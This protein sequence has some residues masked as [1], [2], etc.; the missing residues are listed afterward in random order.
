[1]EIPKAGV[2]IETRFMS[3]VRLTRAFFDSNVLIYADDKG[4]PEKQRIARELIERYF[5]L[6]YGVVSV[7]VLQE[8][9]NTL[10]RKLKA[11]PSLTRQKVEQLGKFVTNIT[12]PE[13]VLMAIDVFRLHGLSFWDS[14][15]VRSA[16]QAD[17][18]ILFSED[19]QH[20]RTID[21]L[22][23]VNPFA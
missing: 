5:S 17:C 22:Q 8:Y 21:G 4:E 23:I 10:T 3:A 12:M 19:M 13:D 14:M 20:G 6:G 16:K 7:Q 2:S 9:F 1:M 18:R 11:D 15:I